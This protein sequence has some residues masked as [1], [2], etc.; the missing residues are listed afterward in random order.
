VTFFQK[1]CG[2]KTKVSIA[3]CARVASNGQEK[4]GKKKKKLLVTTM[5]NS[6]FL[7]FFLS[8]FLTPFFFVFD[9]QMELQQL[10]ECG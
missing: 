5:H 1:S 10:E 2:L 9:V 8:L 7:P 4:R 6:F 3:S